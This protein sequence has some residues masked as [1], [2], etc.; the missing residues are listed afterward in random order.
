MSW[1]IK[2][3]KAFCHTGSGGTPSR[4]QEPIFYGGSIPW[5]KS[6][7]LKEFIVV[8]TKETITEAAL[9]QS[10]AKLIPP[11]SLLVA[12]YG[13]TVGRIA[14]LGIEAASNQ[15]VCHIIPDES[16]ADRRY[17]FYALRTQVPRWLEQRVGGA[18]PNIS[19]QITLLCHSPKQKNKGNF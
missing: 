5:V 18:Q 12:M 3:I 6:G 9:A 17:L 13:A 14:I 7:E 10:S 1:I 8:E 16:L 2:P 15:A 4:Q 19:Q 11:G